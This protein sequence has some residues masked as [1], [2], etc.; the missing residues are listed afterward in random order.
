MMGPNLDHLLASLSTSRISVLVI[1][2]VPRIMVFIWASWKMSPKH[3]W[4]YWVTV[5]NV[6]LL[7][8]VIAIVYGYMLLRL[9]P[10]VNVGAAGEYPWRVAA[11]VSLPI[12]MSAF[13]GNFRILVKMFPWTPL[14][15]LIY[16]SL[17]IYAII[18]GTVTQLELRNKTVNGMDSGLLL[19]YITSQVSYH[20]SLLSR[21]P[22]WTAWQRTMEAK[23][24]AAQA[25]GV[26]LTLDEE[27]IAAMPV[28]ASFATIAAGY[29]SFDEENGETIHYFQNGGNDPALQILRGT[30]DDAA[31][32]VN[33]SALNS[34]R[35]EA[36]AYITEGEF[37]GSDLRL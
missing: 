11:V 27:A 33:L 35:A 5:D 23:A 28:P 18:M 34:L 26:P 4:R 20:V 29:H 22:S 30:N 17:R 32:P 2:G 37:S 12:L 10:A 15:I 13:N 19:L 3:W 8:T 31:V 24:K 36:P 16:K 25:S 14:T 6:L 9:T 7:T 1:V 21:I